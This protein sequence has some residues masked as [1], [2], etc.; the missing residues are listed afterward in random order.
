MLKELSRN[1]EV[2]RGHSSG[3]PNL[4]NREK[5]AIF[6]TFVAIT[7]FFGDASQFLRDDEHFCRCRTSGE[8]LHPSAS[9]LPLFQP[10]L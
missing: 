8:Q 5:E 1:V 7:K 4:S 3:H 9:L 6:E 2:L 10:V